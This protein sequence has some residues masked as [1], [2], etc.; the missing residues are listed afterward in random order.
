MGGHMEASIHQYC[1]DT[2]TCFSFR[3]QFHESEHKEIHN[4]I[5]WGFILMTTDNIR[6]C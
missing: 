2:G 3:F 6:M 5:V 4:D 1:V